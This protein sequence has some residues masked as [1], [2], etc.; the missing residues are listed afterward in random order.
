LQKYQE[1]FLPQNIQ[2]CDPAYILWVLSFFSGVKQLGC[3]VDLS[4]AFNV[5]VK[6]WWN[7]ALHL[8]AFMA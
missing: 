5:E 2:T 3:E 4:P 8:Y 6:S 7:L 1:I